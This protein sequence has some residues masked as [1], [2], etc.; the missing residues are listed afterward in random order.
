MPTDLTDPARYGGY[1]FP[2]AVIHHALWL[3]NRLTLSLRTVQEMLRERGIIVSHE[4]LREWNQKFAEQISLEIKRRRAAPGKTWHLDE[5]HIVVQGKVMWLWRAVDEHG[6]VLDI[7]LQDARDTNAAKHFFERL[8]EGLEFMPG[9]PRRL[10]GE[11]V[12][13]TPMKPVNDPGNVNEGAGPEAS[14]NW[15]SRSMSQA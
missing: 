4:S 7:L 13:C 1:R 11:S 8:L 3:L 5:M 2:K 9:P 15:P 14:S 10:A 12:T 6:M